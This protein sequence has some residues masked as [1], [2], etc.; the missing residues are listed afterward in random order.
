MNASALRLMDAPS[1]ARRLA[2]KK[3]VL[4]NEI[5]GQSSDRHHDEGRVLPEG[6]PWPV[7]H[8]RDISSFGRPT[9][10][11]LFRGPDDPIL[12]RVHG[13]RAVIVTDRDGIVLT[14]G[15]AAI[16]KCWRYFQSLCPLLPMRK[17]LLGQPSITTRTCRRSLR[18]RST[19]AF[20]RQISTWH[21]SRCVCSQTRRADPPY[22][23]EAENVRGWAG[24]EAAARQK[25]EHLSLLRQ[26]HRA[27]CQLQST[28]E[29]FHPSPFYNR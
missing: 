5:L 3:G 2:A 11:E 1:R 24:I 6:G 19:A 14:K 23:T 17:R 25:P 8:F 27:P 9:S 16:P 4:P 12:C 10:R 22:P 13:L 18:R 26:L 7:R 20:S 29:C 15:M 21:L 28:R